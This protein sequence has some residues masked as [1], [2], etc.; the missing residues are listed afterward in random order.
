M[1]GDAGVHVNVW[2]RAQA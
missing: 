2:L 1:Y